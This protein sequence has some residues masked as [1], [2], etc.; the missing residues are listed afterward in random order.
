MNKM[1]ILTVLLIAVVTGFIVFSSCMGEAPE[2]DSLKYLLRMGKYHLTHQEGSIA[3]NYFKDALEIDPD[4]YEGHYGICLSLAHRIFANIDG[5]IDLLAG[6]Y[7]WEPP[8]WDC[9]KACARLKECSLLDEAWTTEETC[10]ADCPFGLQP[11][12]YYT[13]TN[14]DPCY[15]IRNKGLEWIIPT[16]PHNCEALC[17]DLEYCG[18]L[19]P[20]VT[21]DLEGCIS[22]CPHAYVERHSKCYLENLGK[23]NGYERTCFEHTTVGLQILFRKIG[24]HIAPQ[25]YEYS[26]FLIDNPIEYQYYLKD[27]Y[28][29]L[30][31]PPLELDWSGRYDQGFLYMSRAVASV[32]DFILQTATAVQLEMNFPNFDLNFNYSD[33]QGIKEIVDAIIVS[34]EVLLYDPIYPNGFTVVDEDWAYEQVKEGG[35]ALG[36]MFGSAADMFDFM[37]QDSD[38]QAGKALHYSD[39]NE[40]FHWDDGEVMEFTGLDFSLTK[41]QAIALRDLCRAM[42]YNFKDRIPVQINLLTDVLESF[43]LG[44]LDFIIDLLV[45]WSD[46]GTFDASPP[47][48]ECNRYGLRELLATLVDKLKIVQD[49]LDEL[50]IE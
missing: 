34:V 40:N 17:R 44:S 16:K 27:Y 23:C 6:V 7:I 50:G 49:L 26:Q 19:N 2:E 37:F 39:D 20:P 25:L 29:T 18:Q 41:A 21:F 8:V 31:D 14:G 5:I 43:N 22:H 32:F 3:Y 9:E 45:A 48:Y 35:L 33:P 38:R 24:I 46:D 28:W 47:F 11:F 30:V 36:R 15:V 4:N 1:A 42:E 12:M 13:I 10:V